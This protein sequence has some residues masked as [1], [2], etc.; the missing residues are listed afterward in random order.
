MNDL[1]KRM[2]RAHFEGSMRRL[3]VSPSATM[4]WDGLDD[5][6]RD[7]S[8]GAMH[9]ALALLLDPT[10]GMCAAVGWVNLGGRSEGARARRHKTAN[11]KILAYQDMIKHLLEET[12]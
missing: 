6:Q 2:A 5:A 3:G 12:T 1:I 9:D 10:D 8:Y 4:A 7:V 11:D